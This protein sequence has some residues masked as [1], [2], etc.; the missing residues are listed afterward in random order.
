MYVDNIEVKGNNNAFGHVTDSEVCHGLGETL[1]NGTLLHAS[2][3][4]I[5][6]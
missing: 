1:V 5:N 4:E 2:A 3:M 6:S